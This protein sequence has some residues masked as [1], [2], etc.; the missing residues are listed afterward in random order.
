MFEPEDPNSETLSFSERI[1]RLRYVIQ[2]RADASRLQLQ[3]FKDQFFD[4]LNNLK[5]LPLRV[6]DYFT[7]ILQPIGNFFSVGLWFWFGHQFKKL[8]QLWR[9]IVVFF[10]DRETWAERM[11]ARREFAE[12]AR[13]IREAAKTI[14]LETRLNPLEATL[15]NA[16]EQDGSMA[17]RARHLGTVVVFATVV[18]LSTLYVSFVVLKT[19]TDRPKVAD[20]VIVPSVGENDSSSIDTRLADLAT[21]S[22]L[23]GTGDKV[24][25]TQLKS[26]SNEVDAISKRRDVTQGQSRKIDLIRANI[27]GMMFQA[28][29]E[30][31][32]DSKAPKTKLEE[33]VEAYESS[34][35]VEM[36]EAARFWK[37][38]ISVIEFTANPS[39]STHPAYR[40][41]LAQDGEV[42]ESNAVFSTKIAAMLKY[43]SDEHRNNRFTEIGLQGFYDQ[44]KS[45]RD[46]A[47]E[48]TAEEIYELAVFGKFDLPTLRKRL[49]W[50]GFTAKEDL[51]MVLETLERHPDCGEAT[52]TKI[53]R[54]CECLLASKDQTDIKQSVDFVSELVA[55]LP[56]SIKK[57]RLSEQLATQSK[58]IE[59]A[60]AKFDLVGKLN[61]DGKIFEPSNHDYNLIVFVDAQQESTDALAQ[62]KLVADAISSDNQS[63]F[64]A[65]LAYNESVDSSQFDSS[66]LPE[67]ISI[68]TN[69]TSRR[70]HQAFP[71]DDYPYVVLV[72]QMDAVVAANINITE[73]E[74]RISRHRVSKQKQDR[75]ALV[76][77]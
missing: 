20:A 10:R 3:E 54:A 52:W 16:Q 56:D 46:S 4:S 24:S 72:D 42:C 27:E 55:R 60:R 53:I 61:P 8:T 45:S 28:F 57:Q 25:V 31:H 11:A 34:N 62:L 40:N 74:T 71:V 51:N 75:K 69:E 37:M 59:V 38:A 19:D 48:R 6:C 21:Q 15:L 64:H 47:V 66:S 30:S 29:E 18:L 65:V 68:S 49:I 9:D 50:G 41:A 77:Q 17:L 33:F 36:R 7:G 63:V 43:M 76:L 32:V 67:N 22:K 26:V 73:V 12:E 44:I 13:A 58:R 39:E 23:F 5:L 14:E 2:M 35:H 1:E 70:Y